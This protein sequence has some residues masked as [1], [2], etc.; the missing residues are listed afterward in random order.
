[1][2]RGERCV[3]RAH[4]QAKKAEIR[5]GQTTKSTAS[6]SVAHRTPGVPRSFGGLRVLNYFHDSTLLPRADVC[7]TVGNTLHRSRLRDHSP[8]TSRIAARSGLNRENAVSLS[9][10]STER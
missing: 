7:T 4:C 3:L 8:I 6:R 1:M 5:R 2:S 10:P 9:P